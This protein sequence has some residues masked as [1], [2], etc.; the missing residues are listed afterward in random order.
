MSSSDVASSKET[1][2]A[3]PILEVVTAFFAL[4]AIASIVKYSLI[5]RR[6]QFPNGYTRGVDRAT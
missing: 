3:Y 1:M 4:L 2:Q 5:E 6:I